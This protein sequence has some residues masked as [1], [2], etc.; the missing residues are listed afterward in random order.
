MP[1]PRAP[2]GALPPGLLARLGSAG[3]II[4]GQSFICPSAMSFRILLCLSL[5]FP[6]FLVHA[7][8]VWLRSGDRLTGKIK[9][10]DSGKLLLSTNFAG[11]ITIESDKISSVDSTQEVMVRFKEGGPQLLHGLQAGES[12][13]VGLNGSAARPLA[14][15]D[16]RQIVPHKPITKDWR[17]TGN[18][19]GALDQKR[20]DKD[21]DKIDMRAKT[22]LRNRNWRN[23]LEGEYHREV[24]DAK[25]S[26]D[27]Y[28][29]QYALDRFWSDHWFWQGRL[30]YWRDSVDILAVEKDIGTGPGYQFWEDELGA[31]SLTALV[32]RSELELTSPER[33][34]VHFAALGWDYKYFL[35][36]KRLELFSEGNYQKMLEKMNSENLDDIDTM[37]RGRLGLRYKVTS[38]ASLNVR[39]EWERYSFKSDRADNSERRLLMG[40]GV[41]W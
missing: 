31:F 22:V 14:L 1:V 36:A 13:Q 17:W 7:D 2:N 12:G 6:S 26:T 25:V 11:V 34:T 41:N 30:E 37:T 20:A 32:Y 19:D 38:W 24:K 35:L 15:A 23:T 5:L 33:L 40:V 28:S 3:G 18:I 39:T 8:T 16:V 9:L 21:T 29:V 27:N 4:A 10:Y